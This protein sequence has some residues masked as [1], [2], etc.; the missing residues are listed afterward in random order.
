MVGITVHRLAQHQSL[1]F[2]LA[3]DVVLITTNML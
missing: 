1:K 2:Q 3:F